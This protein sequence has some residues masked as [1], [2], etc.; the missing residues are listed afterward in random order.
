MRERDVG[1]DPYSLYGKLGWRKN[2]FSIGE[3][4]MGIDYAYTEN[5]PAVGDD[6]YSFG[7]AAVQQFDDYGTEAYAL[8]RLHSLDR[9]SGVPQ[10]DDIGVFVVG[11]RVKF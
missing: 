9:S 8:Y 10:V 3:T 4:T 5:A 7:V 2:F 11:A 1:S 6:A